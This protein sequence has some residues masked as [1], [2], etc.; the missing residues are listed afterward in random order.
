MTSETPPHL[1]VMHQGVV[2]FE[3]FPL[4]EPLAVFRV[5]GVGFPE[6]TSYL[7]KSGFYIAK[8][9]RYRNFLSFNMLLSNFHDIHIHSLIRVPTTEHPYLIRI[10]L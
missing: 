1:L 7:K 5:V 4:C 3:F 8:R 9:E 2:P 10:C 6:K